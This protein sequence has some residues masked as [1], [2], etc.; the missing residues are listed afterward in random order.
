MI[1]VL[2]IGTLLLIAADA[3]AQQS[4]IQRKALIMEAMAAADLVV[5]MASVVAVSMAAAGVDA[6]MVGTMAPDWRGL[7]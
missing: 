1:R 2:L 3:Y 5:A 7:A 4:V 6:A